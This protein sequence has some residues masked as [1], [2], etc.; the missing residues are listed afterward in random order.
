MVLE[1]PLAQELL[2]E[3]AKQLRSTGDAGLAV[4]GIALR[5]HRTL[6]RL[7][8]AHTLSCTRSG[9]VGLERYWPRANAQGPKLTQSEWTEAMIESFGKAL[10]RR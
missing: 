5:F 2:D 6:L 7:P 1:Q 8:P 9:G 3:Q 4:D 10:R